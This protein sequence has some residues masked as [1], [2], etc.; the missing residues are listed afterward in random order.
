MFKIQKENTDQRKMEF[1]KENRQ[2]KEG[3]EIDALSTA[4]HVEQ[5][6][7]HKL[8]QIRLVA[9]PSD[10]IHHG[11]FRPTNDPVRSGGNIK[12]FPPNQSKAE[13]KWLWLWPCFRTS[14]STSSLFLIRHVVHGMVQRRQVCIN[15]Q[16]CSVYTFLADLSFSNIETVRSYL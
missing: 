3:G 7:D 9:F 15:T 10:R 16:K 2:R 5:V 11:C 1:Q 8:S 4:L 12:G 13:R 6:G 14:T